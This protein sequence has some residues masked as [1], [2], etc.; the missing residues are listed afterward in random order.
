MLVLF[1]LF[2]ITAGT[3][4]VFKCDFERDWCQL[5]NLAGADFLIHENQGRTLTALTG[6]VFDH[7]TRSKDGYY[8]H[9]ECT[10]L[11]KS[12][13]TGGVQT[14]PLH[15]ADG[16]GTVSFWLNS[17]GQDASTFNVY[18]RSAETQ[19]RIERFGP[20]EHT[21]EQA[22]FYH[23]F[24]F[25]LATENFVAVFEFTCGGLKGD[26][27][28]DDIHITCG[29]GKQNDQEHRTELANP[30]ETRNQVGNQC[31]GELVESMSCSF[32]DSTLC[33]WRGENIYFGVGETFTFNTGPAEAHS[34]ESY[35][36]MEASEH[37]Q[38][39][40]V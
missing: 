35:V 10:R 2:T 21:V 23:Q 8:I 20:L 32:D 9:S 22:W 16:L 15:C 1:L 12:G 24:D 14:A 5:E 7:T 28:L 30:N 29:N 6:P 36:Y 26:I 33:G 38:G 27:A 34:P 3:R 13:Q 11:P 19:K 31:Q 40:G 18:L 17:Y 4:T 25:D 37:D 39:Q